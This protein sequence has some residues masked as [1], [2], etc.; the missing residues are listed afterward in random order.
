MGVKYTSL[1]GHNQWKHSE[2]GNSSS[3]DQGV[4]KNVKNCTQHDEYNYGVCTLLMTMV[5]HKGEIE[6]LQHPYTIDELIKCHL[7]FFND[8]FDIFKVVIPNNKF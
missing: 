2:K 3:L 4:L 8:F 1:D 7:R 5:C 6:H